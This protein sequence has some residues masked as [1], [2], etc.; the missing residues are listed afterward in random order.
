[1]NYI[2]NILYLTHA[3][4]VEVNTVAVELPAFGRKEKK[5]AFIIIVGPQIHYVHHMVLIH[6]HEPYNTTHYNEVYIPT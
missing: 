4:Q 2:S 5:N 6:I 1:M 3:M